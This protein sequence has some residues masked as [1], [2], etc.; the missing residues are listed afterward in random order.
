MKKRMYS[1]LLTF[2][3][4]SNVALAFDNGWVFYIK[5]DFGGSYTDPKISKEDMTK[6]QANSFD[7]L[8]DFVKGGI[9]ETGYI[10]GSEKY[11]GL[12][13]NDKF[14]GIGIFG[15][16]SIGE[17]FAGQRSSSIVGEDEI[18]VF[19]NVYYSPVITLDVTARFYFLN[20]KLSL[21]ISGG[22]KMIADPSPTYD[23][24]S[25]EPDVLPSEVGSLIIT[26]K[27]IERMNPFA[28]NMK[29]AVEY[30]LPIFGDNVELTLGTYGAYNIFKPKYI[31]MPPALSEAV[32]PE[33]L[34]NPIDSYYLNSIDFGITV[35]L[36]FLIM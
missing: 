30:N 36:G 9:F 22:T 1:V 11:M 12:R 6:L 32:A 13:D 2:I 5:G 28:V 18:F 20:N 29:L 15:S 16:L 8:I 35:G 34:D 7:G 26:K 14:G 17:G 10:L 3:V 23:F 31:T 27:D 33:V 4:I 25:T 19:F 21:A 24:Y